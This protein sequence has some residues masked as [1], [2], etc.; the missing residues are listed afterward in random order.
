MRHLICFILSGFVLLG[1]GSPGQEISQPKVSKTRVSLN[2]NEIYSGEKIQQFLKNDIKQTEE[3]NKLFLKGID[4]FKNKKDYGSAK[5]LFVKSILKEPTAKSYYELG[6]VLIE[7]GD[8]EDALKAYGLAE[9]LGF[10]P[11]S[12]ILYNKSAVYALKDEN[13]LAADYLEYALQAGYTN[14]RFIDNDPR[15]EN[16]RKSGWYEDALNNGMKGMS[17]PEKLFWLQFKRLFPKINLPIT[18]DPLDQNVDVENMLYIS[19]DFEKYIAEMRDEKF[20]RDVSKGFYHYGVLQETEKYTAVIYVVR[21]EYMA[22][23]APTIYRLATFT[24]DGLLIDKKEIAGR[25]L[26]SEP[27]RYAKIDNDHNIIIDLYE[28]E[29]EKDPGEV[30]YYENK[31]VSKTKIGTE[32]Y[33]LSSDGRIIPLEKQSDLAEN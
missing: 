31:I 2:E 19:Y 8:Y 16:L 28:T 30:G 13:I 12:K 25:D 9:Q 32:K 22:E 18:I 23:W 7:L 21:D 27:M 10:E 11:F 29:Y 14:I 24:P 15:L 17:D 4:D 5:N 6:N 1:C 20:S 33:K 3:A 26:F